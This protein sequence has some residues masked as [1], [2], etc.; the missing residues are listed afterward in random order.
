MPRRAAKRSDTRTAKSPASIGSRQ[1]WQHFSLCGDSTRTISSL[2]RVE[3]TSLMSL[4][5]RPSFKDGAISRAGA[6]GLGALTGEWR[7]GLLD[8]GGWMW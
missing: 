8:I 5:G 6:G 7:L 3:S 4:S 2:G 1:S